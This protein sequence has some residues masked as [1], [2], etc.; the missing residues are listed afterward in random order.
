MVYDWDNLAKH[1]EDNTTNTQFVGQVFQQ[2]KTLTS[3]DGKH[4]LD[5]GCGTG[6]LSQMMSPFVKSIVALDASESM[7]EEL[8]QKEL[9][10]VEP[11]VDALTRGLV[12]QHP[13]FRK[14]FD[15]IVAASVCGYVDDFA[16]V[17]DIIYSLL[18]D[19]GVFIQWDWLAQSSLAEH[20]LDE[21]KVR[22]ALSQA[23]F[24]AI[25]VAQAFVIETESGP[26]AAFFAIGRKL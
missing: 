3:L 2:L 6:L 14:Q 8:D 13:A 24:S 17:A 10:N 4:V 7:I 15:L 12:A 21:I 18:D 1:W 22:N 5:Y 26:Q 23:G 16:Q 25:E 9:A 11:V 20:Q 19:G